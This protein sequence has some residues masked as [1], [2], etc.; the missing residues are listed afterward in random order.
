MIAVLRLDDDRQT[1]LL[2]GIPGVVG[3]GDGTALRH[4]HTDDVQQSARQLLVL[5]DHLGDGAG[6]VG[7][8]GA[9]AALPRAVAEL[10]ETAAV[11]PAH[12]N[13]ATQGSLDDG[14]GAGSE[15]DIVGQIA[16]TDQIGG[17]IEGAIG[18][19]GQDEFS[20]RLQTGA[21]EILF[22]VLDDDAEETIAATRTYQAEVHGTSGQA[23]QFERQV[24]E[25][26][27]A[28]R[29]YGTMG[30]RR[31]RG[32]E[33]SSACSEAIFRYGREARQVQFYLQHGTGAPRR[34]RRARSRCAAI[35]CRLLFP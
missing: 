27:G 4:R 33:T 32:A 24:A 16:Q 22:L 25:E 3:V 15:A 6:G 8:G 19:G 10:H 1:D 21:A 17:E 34:S 29:T 35:P 18:Q 14:G 20:R 23:L 13:A 26:S 28:I 31:H 12:R 11:E 2:G 5:G 30:E 7:F 9:D